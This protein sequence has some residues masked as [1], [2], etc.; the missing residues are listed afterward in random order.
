MAH[1]ASHLA[2]QALN[3]NMNHFYR[4]IKPPFIQQKQ[5]VQVFRRS[6]NTCTTCFCWIFYQKRAID[7]VNGSLLIIIEKI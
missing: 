6:R 2:L 5:V 7:A 1:A 3:L 4:A